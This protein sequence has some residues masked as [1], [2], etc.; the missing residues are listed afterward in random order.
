VVAR[1]RICP[2]KVP[3]LLRRGLRGKEE[4]WNPKNR[5]ASGKDRFEE[6]DR[7]PGYE[8]WIAAARR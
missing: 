8:V 1:L 3:G 2:A 7:L 4:P 5:T 6:E